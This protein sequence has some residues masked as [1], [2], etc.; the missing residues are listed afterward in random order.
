MKRVMTLAAGALIG[1]TA[2]CTN[3]GANY[4]PI[5]DGPV[6]PNY[7][8]DLAQCQQLAASK[9]VLDSGSAGQAAIGAGVGAATAAIVEDTGS[10]IGK[11]AAVGA[12]V[13]LTSNAINNDQQREN[14]VKS[15]MRSRGYNVVG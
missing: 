12:L 5:I 3:T 4:Q 11:G 14:I 2:A 1:L 6:G 9:P 15:C 7:N 10:N 13:G 8:N